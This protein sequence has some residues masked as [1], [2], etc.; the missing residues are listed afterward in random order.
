M[1]NFLSAQHF[2]VLL[3]IIFM[4]NSFAVELQKYIAQ[5][6]AQLQ[7]WL[8][9]DPT[10]SLALRIVKGIYKSLAVLVLTALSPVILVILVVTFLAAF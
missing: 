10:D 8:K 6:V 9:A 7:E 1:T 2:S 4:N 3:L 5:K